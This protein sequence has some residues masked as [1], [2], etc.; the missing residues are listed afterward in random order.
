[1]TRRPELQPQEY[2][3]SITGSAASFPPAPTPG[4]EENFPDARLYRQH[5][6]GPAP[7]RPLRLT[8]LVPCPSSS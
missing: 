3:D 1:M 8:L 6:A 4:E 5:G 2:G 7:P